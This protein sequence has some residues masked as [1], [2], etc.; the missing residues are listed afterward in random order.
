MAFIGM[1]VEAV[2]QLA[3]QLDNK[4]TDIDSIMSTLNSKL[5]STDWVGSDA[6]NFR[7]DWSSVHM[8]N[9][10]NVSNA[11]K[12]A[13]KSARTNADDQDTASNK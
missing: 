6:T 2:R 13:A 11:L 1:D 12:D 7:N 10:R 9:L 5:N 3:I 4:A 8:T